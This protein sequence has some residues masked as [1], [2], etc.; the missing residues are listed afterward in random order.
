MKIVKELTMADAK[1]LGV[2]SAYNAGL[3]AE[4]CLEAR[5]YLFTPYKPDDEPLA[6]AGSIEDDG[7]LDKA[8]K[9]PD[10]TEDL[11]AALIEALIHGEY[12]QPAYD[13]HLA[14]TDP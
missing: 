1:R 10:F 9:N 11:L 7:F 13:G 3:V 4:W 2:D 6:G 5:R 12:V 8:L 14:E